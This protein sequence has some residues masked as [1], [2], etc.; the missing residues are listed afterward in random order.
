MKTE[1]QSRVAWSNLTAASWNSNLTSVI[2]VEDILV[3]KNPYDWSPSSEETLFCNLCLECSSLSRKFCWALGSIYCLTHDNWV[4]FQVWDIDLDAFIFSFCAV[5]LLQWWQYLRPSAVWSWLLRVPLWW[6]R[7]FFLWWQT[8]G[9]CTTKFQKHKVIP[10]FR[11]CLPLNRGLDMMTSRITS[12]LNHFMILPQI[13]SHVSQVRLVIS[14]AYSLICI[15]ADETEFWLL[16]LLYQ[17]TCA[18]WKN[19][20]CI[21]YFWCL[22]SFVVTLLPAHVAWYCGKSAVILSNVSF[23]QSN[24]NIH[25]DCTSWLLKCNRE[26]WNCSFIVLHYLPEEKGW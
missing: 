2:C 19:F 8:P 21:L 15:V 11:A 22:K 25:S 14:R 16:G 12:D 4:P 6:A 3:C 20:W 9:R 1:L 23:K 24:P 17:Q 18:F 10:A 13:L 5:F 26:H 7:F